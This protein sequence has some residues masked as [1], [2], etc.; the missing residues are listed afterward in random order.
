MI[1][2]WM[3]Q[4]SHYGVNRSSFGI[5]SPVNQ[6]LN[7]CVNQRARAHRTRLNC[8]KQVAATQ[9]VIAKRRASF[10]KGND[11]G[12][13]AGVVAG[14][15]PIPSTPDNPSCMNHYRADRNFAR[16][17]RALAGAKRFFHP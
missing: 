3:V 1:Q 13:R 5:V 10:T 9:T 17:Q 15:Y 2:A 14:N 8:S 7:S 4:Y 12:V 6:A 11:F 16:F